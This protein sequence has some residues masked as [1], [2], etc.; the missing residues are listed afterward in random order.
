[1]THAND[2]LK[3]HTSTENYYRHWILGFKFTDGV[4]AFADQC[5]AYWFIN[6]I[7]SHQVDPNVKA[8][9]FQV[10]DLKR[11]NSNRFRAICTDGN[12]NQVTQQS[13][14]FSDFPFDSA[15]IWLVE[16]VILLPSEY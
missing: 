8:E 14:P 16:G 6:L 7:V 15:T 9:S 10:W 11:L 12:K 3:A 2:S 5:N 13:I 4:K 1:M